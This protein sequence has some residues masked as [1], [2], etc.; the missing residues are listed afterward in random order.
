[1]QYCCLFLPLL[2]P[3]LFR[4]AA[5]EVESRERGARMFGVS[6]ESSRGRWWRAERRLA[7]HRQSTG[8]KRTQHCCDH[9]Y[10]YYTIENPFGHV[11]LCVFYSLYL[12]PGRH[13]PLSHS[14]SPPHPVTHSIFHSLARLLT[15]LTPLTALNNFRL[16]PRKSLFLLVQACFCFHEQSAP[17]A[18]SCCIDFCSFSFL[19][20]SSGKIKRV[21]ERFVTPLK[22]MASSLFAAAALV[23]A[24]ASSSAAAADA[25]AMEIPSTME[26]VVC[27]RELTH[28]NYSAMDDW[29][30][31]LA[32]P[33]PVK[34]QVRST[35]VSAAL[36]LSLLSILASTHRRFCL[37]VFFSLPVSLCCAFRLFMSRFFIAC[38]IVRGCMETDALDSI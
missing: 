31:P 9:N 8:K 34:S 33:T 32:V 28:K 11:C 1:M 21:T 27:V 14:P 35:R 25:A 38:T 12:H 36:L 24:S 22:I 4:F 16:P 18:V 37:F 3:H 30:T 7:T 13:A 29:L 15:R 19:F 5:C 26:A 20:V 10:L 6:L 17:P 23:V 2:F